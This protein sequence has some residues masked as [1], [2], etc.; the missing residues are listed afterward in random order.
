MNLR[1]R[2]ISL[3]RRGRRRFWLLQAGEAILLAA[4]SYV[5][6]GLLGERI[7]G[8]SGLAPDTRLWL[9]IATGLAV[10]AGAGWLVLHGRRSPGRRLDATGVARRLDG[11]HA[12]LED[13]SE[14]LLRTREETDGPPRTLID[15]QG[16]RIAERLARLNRERRL[17]SVLP[18]VSPLTL[19]VLGLSLAASVLLLSWLPAQRTPWT[20][21]E[22]V[23]PV[24][25]GTSRGAILESRIEVIP[26]RYT[27]LESYVID[28][29]AVEAPEGS[30]L[31]WRL[32]LPSHAGDAALVF[33]DRQRIPLQ[34]DDGK[35]A[36]DRGGHWWHS[37]VVDARTALYSVS[38]KGLRGRR[39]RIDP[40][41]DRP[42]SVA[43]LE[44]AEN[45]IELQGA[46]DA[47]LRLAARAGDEYGLDLVRA[48]MTLARGSGENVRF[49]EQVFDLE[50]PADPGREAV[51]EGDWDLVDLGMEA[52]DELYLWVEAL[53]SREPE[54]NLGRSPALILRWPGPDTQPQ[55]AAEGIAVRVIPEF[56]RSQR[57]IIIDTEA[58]IE[59]APG[60]TEDAFA[61]RSQELATDQKLL[62]MRYGQ[63]LGEE[64]VSQVGPG[65]DSA[66]PEGEADGDDHED[67]QEAGETA[68][69]PH[70]FAALSSPLAEFVHSHDVA[71]QS[72]LFEEDT[73]RTLK[74]ALAEMWD[75]ELHLRLA[76]PHDALP[77][78]NA[79][80]DLIKRV[81]QKSRIYLRRA[82]FR[83]S[84]LE[85]SRRFSGEVEQVPRRRTRVGE[86]RLETVRL[87][88]SVA[89][90]LGDPGA[91]GE[92]TGGEFARVAAWLEASS[93][94]E[95]EKLEGLAALEDLR[96]SS[97]CRSCRQRLLGL[98]RGAL[99]GSGP[100]ALPRQA[101]DSA[102]SRAFL[103]RIEARAG[104]WEP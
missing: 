34:R 98:L 19:V 10:L 103:D 63:F 64:F 11:R 35:A 37:P 43:L 28:T 33:H 88:R 51:F 77:S 101:T 89:A 68:S 21:L 62:R 70:N 66:G 100:A 4:T 18:E 14:L 45:V 60:L 25:G 79:A 32:R 81:Q 3:A 17:E 41:P 7:L 46:D 71:E 31:R 86:P 12:E 95:G 8:L 90:R 84:P 85:E 27:G 16:R 44:P 59:A 61:G 94:T 2:L 96:L 23:G 56:F 97:D 75:A 104:Q 5:G 93:L 78:E 50:G 65:V 73:K 92:F 55:T 39:H 82:G 38:G 30:R 57:Q 36:E 20:G 1:R 87:L 13:S 29:P 52:G 67:H 22:T 42:P 102:V 72:T 54:P 9:Q 99:P 58:L 15:L 6:L 26:P 48:R 40:I 80:L 69:E 91:G 83:S 49:R 53:D 47:T 74:Q 76:N 24:G